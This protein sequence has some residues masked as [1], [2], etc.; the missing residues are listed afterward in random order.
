MC[1]FRGYWALSGPGAVAGEGTRDNTLSAELSP[2]LELA[3]GTQG[4][5]LGDLPIIPHSCCLPPDWIRLT[6]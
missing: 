2:E 3:P 6:E 5:E 1:H 4:P